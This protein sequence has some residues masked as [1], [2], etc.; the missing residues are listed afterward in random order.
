[1]EA[2]KS[3]TAYILYVADVFSSSSGL[4]FLKPDHM[5]IEVE[6]RFTSR[7]VI[8]NIR[9]LRALVEGYPPLIITG[10]TTSQ[11]AQ[12]TARLEVLIEGAS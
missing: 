9:H 6:P 2:M 7:D 4:D 12:M 5:A 11:S 1:M 10:V 8:W 3:R